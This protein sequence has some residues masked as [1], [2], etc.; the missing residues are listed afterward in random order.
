M[1]FSQSIPDSAGQVFE[2]ALQANLS[3]LVLIILLVGAVG[4]VMIV[5]VLSRN[6]TNTGRAAQ[7]A[8]EFSRALVETNSK[9]TERLANSID[10]LAEALALMREVQ[11]LQVSR[12]NQLDTLHDLLD[13]ISSEL[14][15][16]RKDIVTLI[17]GG[18]K[19]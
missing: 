2:A 10:G 11:S 5:W 8:S 13:S 3:N 15:A 18:D 19:A 6:V 4:F 7:S 14:V 1:Y 16:A 9:V 12:L 17:E